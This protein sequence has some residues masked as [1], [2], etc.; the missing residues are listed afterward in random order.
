MVKINIV[1]SFIFAVFTAQ[2]VTILVH[3]TIAPHKQVIKNTLEWWLP[4]GA[5][6]ENLRVTVEAR[7]DFLIP[8][9]WSGILSSGA[10]EQAAIVLAKLITS[11]PAS[12]RI[13]L[14]GHSLGGEVIARALGIIYEPLKKRAVKCSVA[15]VEGYLRQYFA[16]H[17]EPRQVCL[18]YALDAVG[19]VEPSGF[20]LKPTLSNEVR[21][22][23]WGSSNHSTCVQSQGIRQFFIDEIYMLGTPIDEKFYLHIPEMVGHLVNI[24]SKGDSVQPVAGIYDRKLVNRPKIANIELFVHQEK[25]SVFV[26]PKHSELHSPML[27]THLFSIVD[28]LS[29]SKPLWQLSGVD[30]KLAVDWVQGPVYCAGLPSVASSCSVI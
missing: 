25:T 23:V 7:G 8:F 21:D 26:S 22:I 13:V 24:Y 12:E 11:Y 15:N 16:Q 2:P 10:R 18:S 5:F 4:G 9:C 29:K 14:V 19:Y 1:F 6:Y 3:G 17:Q 28:F 20:D 27:G 30:I